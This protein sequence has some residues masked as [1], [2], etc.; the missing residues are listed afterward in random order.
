MPQPPFILIND[1][2]GE[3]LSSRPDSV[4]LPEPGDKSVNL[5]VCRNLSIELHGEMFSVT[6]RLTV[7]EAF[8]VIAMLNYALREI[9][10]KPEVR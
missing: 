9:L 10:Y 4:P 6:K 2:F 3:V 1:K 8:G 5:K 7:D